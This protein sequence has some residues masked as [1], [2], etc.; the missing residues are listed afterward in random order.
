MRKVRSVARAP[1]IHANRIADFHGFPSP[2]LPD[3]HIGWKAFKL[4]LD[5]SA[6]VVL[7]IQ[8]E[9]NV[10][11]FPI[12]LGNYASDVD[13]FRV[14]IFGPKGMMRKCGSRNQKCD[15]RNQK[16]S[17]HIETW[18]TLYLARREPKNLFGI[19]LV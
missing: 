15:S 11:I 13:R 18:G 2:S 1:S 8:I 6:R 12:H 17:S 14:V 19:G 9:M 16:M 3:Q 4:P 5:Y 10:R 7:H